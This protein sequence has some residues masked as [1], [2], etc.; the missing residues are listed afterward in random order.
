MT[1]KLAIWL[2]LI[3]LGLIG[4]DFFLN[5]GT[6]MLFLL[7]KLADAIEWLAFWR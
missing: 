2:G 3:V 6:A 4:T 1:D 7:R 5:D